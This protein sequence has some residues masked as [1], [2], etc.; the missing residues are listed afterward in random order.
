MLPSARDGHSQPVVTHETC[1]HAILR[2]KGHSVF[3]KNRVTKRYSD[4]EEF[5]WIEEKKEN[6]EGYLT[7][8]LGGCKTNRSTKWTDK[9]REPRKKGEDGRQSKKS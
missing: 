4:A 9:R 5:G 8:E 7:V 2:S 3:S 6:E 1:S